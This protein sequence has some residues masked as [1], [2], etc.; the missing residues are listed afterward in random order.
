MADA[1]YACSSNN[2]RNSIL[3]GNFRNHIIATHPS[4]DNSDMPPQHTIGIGAVIRSSVAKK[5][6]SVKIDRVLCYRITTTCGD[7]NAMVGFKHIDP[8]LYLYVGAY[9]IWVLDNK[10]RKEKAPGRNGSLC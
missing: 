9:I 6:K 3:A 10:H 4:V 7:N 5:V 1:A 8:A 2:E